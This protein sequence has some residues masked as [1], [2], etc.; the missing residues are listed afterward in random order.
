M[1]PAS[2]HSQPPKLARLQKE[3]FLAYRMLL[4][5]FLIVLSIVLLPLL[6]NFWI[7]F[8]AVELGD[9]RAARPDVQRTGE[10]ASEIKLT[11]RSL[12]AIGSET[13]PKK[14]R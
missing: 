3:R 2:V 10:A 1:R 5:T 8:K 7:S 11:K 12:F 4:P 13:H 14:K 9:L 6:A